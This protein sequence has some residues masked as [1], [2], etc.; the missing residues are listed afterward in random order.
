MT[1]RYWASGIGFVAVHQL[2]DFAFGD[3]VGG[4]GQHVHDAH[5]PDFHHHLKRARIEKVA[6][7]D[8]GFVA[9]NA[10]GR[11]LAA[12]QVRVVDH[13][14]VEQGGRVDKLDNGSRR[15]VLIACIAAGAG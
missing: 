11:V 3:G 7:Q 8:T 12:A 14:I 4:I 10:V 13:V 6:Y 2:Q 5:L 1:S 15:D 9:E